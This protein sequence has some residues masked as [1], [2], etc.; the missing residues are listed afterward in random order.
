MTTVDPTAL[1]TWN[2]AGDRARK[3][4]RDDPFAAAGIGAKSCH[5][6]RRGSHQRCGTTAINGLG[7]VTCRCWLNDHERTAA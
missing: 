2:E 4:Y 5:R 7:F 6:C 1:V 3:A